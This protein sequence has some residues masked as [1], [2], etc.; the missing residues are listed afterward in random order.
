ME[1]KI[2]EKFI[3]DFY[4][5]YYTHDRDQFYRMLSNSFRNRISF[6]AFNQRRQYALID[7][8]RLKEIETINITNH[9]IKVSCKIL[10]HHHIIKYTF[11]LLNE[12]GNLYIKPDPFMFAK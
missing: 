5:A 12:N 3:H 6:E 10:I 4:H 2:I 8:G 9:E 1:K 7:I 11:T